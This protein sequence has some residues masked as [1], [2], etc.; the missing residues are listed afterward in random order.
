M[1]WFKN[2]TKV[3]AL[4]SPMFFLTSSS[5]CN[6]K[7][8]DNVFRF[9]SNRSLKFNDDIGVDYR[10]VRIGKYEND[11]LICESNKLALRDE[12]ELII[13]FMENTLN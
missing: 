9:I 4:S 3:I 11:V 1:F 6:T 2:D 5:A 12:L 8:I 13:R 10:V 7:N